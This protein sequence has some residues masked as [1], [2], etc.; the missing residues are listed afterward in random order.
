MWEPAGMKGGGRR[1]VRRPGAV[2][3]ALLFGTTAAALALTLFYHLGVP[4]S[5]VTFLFGLPGLYLG[6]VALQDA[7]AAR[8]KLGADSRRTRCPAPLPVGR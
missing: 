3:L 7:G 5:V 4:G 6:W 8:P 2:V 1:R